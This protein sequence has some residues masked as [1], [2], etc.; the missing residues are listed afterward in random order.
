MDFKIQFGKAKVSKK[1]LPNI[2]DPQ[3]KW[4][5]LNPKPSDIDVLIIEW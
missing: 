4:N 5:Y 3:N 2:D 1:Q